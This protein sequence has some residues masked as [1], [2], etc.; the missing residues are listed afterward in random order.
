VHANTAFALAF[1]F[2]YACR[3]QAAGLRAA[4]AAKAREWYLA[5][6]DAPAAWE[7]SGA[8][9]LSPSLT[10]AA[11]KRRF[12]EP[13]EFSAWLARFLP[14]LERREPAALF[15][16]ARVGDRSDPYLVHL[17]GLNLARAWCWRDIAAALGV[18]DRRRAIAHDAATAHL[19][20]GLPALDSD[21]YVGTHWLATF[22][23]LALTT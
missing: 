13:V 10:E 22:A 14:H 2:D 17:D 4:V 11:L 8:D 5:D 6:R 12:L 9:F 18:D 3:C 16:P 7:P 21:D 15:V 23:V 20:A 1:A 19:R